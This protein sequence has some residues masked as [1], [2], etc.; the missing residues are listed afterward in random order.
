MFTINK[1][2]F[3]NILNDVNKSCVYRNVKDKAF[4]EITK[5]NNILD[6]VDLN[7]YA[8]DYVQNRLIV[9]RKR[10]LPFDKF[11]NL[12]ICPLDTPK[13]LPT[14]SCDSISYT[15]PT[16][17]KKSYLTT[18]TSGTNESLCIKGFMNPGILNA[19]LIYMLDTKL[20]SDETMIV[21]SLKANSIKR[22]DDDIIEYL[23][24]NYLNSM[25]SNFKNIINFNYTGL[26]KGY[27]KQNY[28]SK[29]RIES[30][31]PNEALINLRKLCEVESIDYR[32]DYNFDVE[33]YQ[34][35]KFLDNYRKILMYFNIPN[36]IESRLFI[37]AQNKVEA[38][39][40]VI[41]NNE[42]LVEWNSVEKFINHIYYLIKRREIF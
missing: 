3:L 41:T 13:P 20:I 9:I 31:F 19:I 7:E 25:N 4:S 22:D 1:E 32:K 26:E 34:M 12:V 33:V 10:H 30:K 15:F 18:P 16:E 27:P 40:S 37:F 42:F 24:K 6:Y 11:K 14:D 23:Q 5:F 29:F 39:F 38:K 17:K 2:K 36:Y 21:L 28:T 8:L 35:P